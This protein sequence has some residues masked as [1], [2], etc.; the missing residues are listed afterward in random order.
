[1]K[2]TIQMV[3]I[4]LLVCVLPQV[5]LSYDADEIDQKLR[6]QGVYDEILE[7]D[8]YVSF[9]DNSYANLSE[10]RISELVQEKFTRL[11]PESLAEEE[12]YSNIFEYKFDRDRETMIVRNRLDL[13][14]DKADITS[15]LDHAYIIELAKQDLIKLGIKQVNDKDMDIAVFNLVRREMPVVDPEQLKQMQMSFRIQKKTIAYKVRVHRKIK[16]KRLWG[17]RMTLSYFMDGSIN[18]IQMRWPK[19]KD[20]GRAVRSSSSEDEILDRVHRTLNEHELHKASKLDFDVIYV[21]RNGQIKQEVVI[22]GKI[23]KFDKKGEKLESEL[24]A[25]VEI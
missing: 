12:G 3:T 19:I 15:A 21:V 9:D 20:M 14:A 7:S 18:K 10:E 11:S 17:P 6:D 1:M 23:A 22:K 13:F 24:I 2:K 25:N 8:E 5:A 4:S 16:G